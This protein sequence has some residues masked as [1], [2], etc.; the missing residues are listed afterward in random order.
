MDRRKVRAQRG[1]QPAVGQVGP[2]PSLA[3]WPW[4]LFQGLLGQYVCLG[5]LP[6]PPLSPFPPAARC[7]GVRALSLEIFVSLSSAWQ[8]RRGST[9]ALC[10]VAPNS[11]W[12]WEP[13]VWRMGRRQRHHCLS[14]GNWSIHVQ[15]KGQKGEEWPRLRLPVAM[16]SMGLPGRPVTRQQ[17]RD[18]DK[19]SRCEG[20]VW[21]RCECVG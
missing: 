12:A 1:T 5:T 2:L 16:V 8:G 11:F 13:A 19:G 10:A 18:Q 15:C 6:S 17:E 14:T 4:L 7:A 20:E 3:L 9:K 21:G